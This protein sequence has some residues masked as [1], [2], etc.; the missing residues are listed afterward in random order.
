L[1]EKEKLR[2]AN[3]YL[4]FFMDD[5]CEYDFSRMDDEDIESWAKRI[6]MKSSSLK[7]LGEECRQSIMM[8]SCCDQGAIR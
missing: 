2:R 3:D 4:M 7:T 8:L 6:Y 5:L 1:D